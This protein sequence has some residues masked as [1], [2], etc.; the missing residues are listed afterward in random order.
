M[1]GICSPYR[2]C[3]STHA[4]LAIAK[5]LEHIGCEYRLITSGWRSPRIDRA[6]D[7]KVNTHKSLNK[8]DNIIWTETTPE[9]FDILVNRPQ[10]RNTIYTGWDNLQTYD[11]EV[12]TTYS[13]VLLPTPVQAAQIRDVFRLQNVA[14]LPF[15]CGLPITKRGKQLINK[16]KIS[17][18]V[19]LYGNQLRTIDLAGI[20]MLAN[21]L[22]NNPN[23][24]LTIAYAGGLANYTAKEFDL[25]TQK[26]NNRF[27]VLYTADW[28]T[29]VKLMSYSDLVVLL[30]K[31]DGFGLISNTALHLGVPLISWN[32][33]PIN[34]QLIASRNAILVDCETRHDPVGLQAVV[35]NYKEFERL[36]R[37]LIREPENIC[38]LKGHT[39]E[40]LEEWDTEFGN[41]LK[42]ILRLN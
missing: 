16:D 20:M 6:Y 4:A 7:H 31:W 18:F 10:I 32:V 19:S 40:Q 21:V 38:K 37:W 8:I 23:T 39:H 22:I 11:D 5:Y 41:G 24:E 29:H 13:Y 3:D 33:P 2:R 12:L 1:I 42:T 17:L 30:T 28:S 25:L 36:L 15:S 34:E 35:S 9:Y 14:V 26:L 27:K